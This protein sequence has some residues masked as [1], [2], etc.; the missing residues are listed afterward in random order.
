MNLVNTNFLKEISCP[1]TTFF[2][3]QIHLSICKCHN[4]V[5]KTPIDVILFALETLV[6]LIFATKISKFLG[7][8]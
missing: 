3:F 6:C 4:S 8:K 7:T 5:C 1:S 2:V